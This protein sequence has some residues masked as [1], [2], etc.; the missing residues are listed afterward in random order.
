[1]IA[2]HTINIILT[3]VT[4]WWLWVWK[5]CIQ[6]KHCLQEIDLFFHFIDSFSSLLG[7]KKTSHIMTQSMLAWH[8]HNWYK[9]RNFSTLQQTYRLWEREP[10]NTLWVLL[11]ERADWDHLQNIIYDILLYISTQNTEG[12][13]KYNIYLISSL[14]PFQ[15]V[16]S[17]ILHTEYLY[18]I[19]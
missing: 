2:M 4:Y 9:K 14:I 7:V 3:I 16:G 10:D 18:S 19:L 6:K 12:G 5:K 8:D 11:L 15:W 17:A 1:M 13:L